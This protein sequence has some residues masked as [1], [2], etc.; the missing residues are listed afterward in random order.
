MTYLRPEVGSNWPYAQMRNETRDLTKKF[1]DAADDRLHA[2]V[3]GQ[4]DAIVFRGSRVSR[5]VTPLVEAELTADRRQALSGL[6]P[7]VS[8]PTSAALSG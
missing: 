8:T 6:T 3:K 5:A 4:L 1:I 7:G 2:Y